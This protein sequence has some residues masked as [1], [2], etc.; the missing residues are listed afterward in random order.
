LFALAQITEGKKLIEPAVVSYNED[1]DAYFLDQEFSALH[2]DDLWDC[3]EWYLNFPES[4]PPDQNPL[5]YAH[6]CEQQQHDGKLL[7]L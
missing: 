2:D 7:A 1:E 5:H 4:D 6:I 3:I